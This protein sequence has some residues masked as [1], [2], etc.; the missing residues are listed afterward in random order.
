MNVGRQ[1]SSNHICTHMSSGYSPSLTE[2]LSGRSLY[3]IDVSPSSTTKECYFYFGG[4]GNNTHC[5]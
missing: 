5:R 2:S 1:I 3:D 4:S